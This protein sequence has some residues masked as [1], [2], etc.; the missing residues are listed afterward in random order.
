MFRDGR[1]ELDNNFS[2]RKA[3]KPFVMG[4]K[5]S[6][7]AITHNDAE[8]TCGCYSIVRTAQFNGLVL[9]EYLVSLFDSLPYK[10][11]K[12]FDYTSYLPWADGIKERV[13]EHIAN[14]FRD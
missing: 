5:N 10:E 7:F 2:E 6:L 4:R 11:D 9:Y 13:K 8:M 1:L 3:I 14:K 12:R